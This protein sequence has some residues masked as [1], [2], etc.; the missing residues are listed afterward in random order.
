MAV[1]GAKGSREKVFGTP[2]PAPDPIGDVLAGK[3]EMTPAMRRELFHEAAVRAARTDFLAFCRYM[4]PDPADEEDPEKTGFMTPPHIRYLGNV[5]MKVEKGDRD[6][7]RL[8]ISMPPGHGKSELATRL[9][10]L[11]FMGRNPKRRCIL[12]GYSETFA[13]SEF[14][15]KIRRYMQA[16]RFK[17]VFPDCSLDGGSKAVDR[18]ITTVGGEVISVGRGGAITGRRGDL[19]IGDDIIKGDEEAQS[20]TIRDKAWAWFTNDFSTRGVMGGS[21]RIIMIGTRW[22]LDDP[23]GRL[24]DPASSYSNPSIRKI[25]KY[26]KLPAILTDEHADIAKALG[27][28]IGEVLWPEAY[29][30][31]FL[32]ERRTT[33]ARSFQC[34]YQQDPAPEDGSHFKKAHFRFY[35]SPQAF[36]KEVR[37]YAASDHALTAKQNRDASVLIPFGIDQDGNIWIHHDTWWGREESHQVI[38]RMVG[39]KKKF[40]GIYEWF[41]GRE[42]ITGSIG[43]VLRKRCQEER[44]AL[45]FNELPNRGDKIQKSQSIKA[46]MAMGTV[47]FPSFA[48]WWAKAEAEI[49]KFPNGSHDDFVDALG[50]IGQA[51]DGMVKAKGAPKVSEEPVRGTWAWIKWS[52]KRNAARE[53]ARK[54]D[55]W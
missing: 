22:H 49:L 47:Y 16:D 39:I 43:P 55:G 20:P 11:W 52:S 31:E 36:P 14:G 41:A 23:I 17:R 4:T 51:L 50:V 12:A 9:F 32:E 28:A 25:W 5:L 40:K 26:I 21:D 53:A 30:L 24:C 13:E 3:I 29:G 54:S 15:M 18:L 10:V 44:L 37:W 38:D 46:R 42:H 8:A 7:R 27:R 1:S 19:L 6:W 2:A 45:Q 34:L 33:D 35:N 48:P